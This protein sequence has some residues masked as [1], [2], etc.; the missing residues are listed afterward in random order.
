MAAAPSSCAGVLPKA[1]LKEPTAVRAAL[2]MTIEGLLLG[3]SSYLL[4]LME[5]DWQREERESNG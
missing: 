4:C 2:A 3:R 5:A 1:P